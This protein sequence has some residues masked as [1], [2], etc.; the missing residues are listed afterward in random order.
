MGGPPEDGKKVV[1][2]GKDGLKG[3]GAFNT[4]SGPPAHGPQS[5]SQPIEAPLWPG[6]AHPAMKLV[7]PKAAGSNPG[8]ALLVFQGGA[9][10]SCMGSGGG[11]A[12]RAAGQ[13]MGGISVEYGNRR[14]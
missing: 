14:S 7:F 9:H 12:E 6:R 4:P 11:S 1:V 2:C 5:F 3:K 8:L 13:G 10:A